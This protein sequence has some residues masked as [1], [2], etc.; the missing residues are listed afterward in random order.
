M[1]HFGHHTGNCN[2]RHT[3]ECLEFDVFD[4]VIPDFN[5]FFSKLVGEKEPGFKGSRG[6]VVVDALIQMTL[7]LAFFLPYSSIFSKGCSYKKMLPGIKILSLFICL[8][9]FSLE[10]LNPWFLID[11]PTLWEK[12]HKCY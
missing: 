12:I 5:R 2:C 9:D 8:R 6:Q 7:R 10:P 1:G 4:D 11:R 3:T